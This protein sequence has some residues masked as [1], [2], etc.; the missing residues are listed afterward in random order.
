MHIV[1]GTSFNAAANQ[2]RDRDGKLHL[3][4]VVKGTFDIPMQ[5]T[6]S[7]QV[8]ETQIPI[9]H[10]DVFEGEPGLTA[11]VFESDWV[12]RK[13][14]CDIVVKANA[15]APEGSPIK[16]MTAGFRVG[17]CQKLATVVG[18]RRWKKNRLGVELGNAEPFESMPIKYDN[19]FGGLWHDPDEDKY[20]CYA[21]NPNGRGFAKQFQDQLDETHYGPTIEQP[22]RPVTDSDSD[23]QPWGFGPI[24]RNWSPRSD[25]AG[26]YDDHWKQNVFPLLPADFDERFFQCV[27]EDQ[28]VDFLTGGEE[29][30]LSNLDPEHKSLKFCLP[31]DLSMPVIVV[32]RKRAVVRVTTVADTLSIDATTR[33]FTIVWRGQLPLRRGL[34]EINSVVAGSVCK[35]W[36]KSLIF[37]GS[38]CSC[39]GREEKPSKMMSVDEVPTP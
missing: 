4:L 8:S 23:Y 31:H 34:R 11:P 32:D 12:L 37:G 26:T 36:W 5:E 1:N 13:K 15:Y 21:A 7:P 39:D 38:E 35:R 2:S 20:E 10:S 14:R 27:P 9:F 17:Q 22:D 33:Q 28:Q 16:S 3:L 30:E 19:S 6:Q 18:I 25:Y 24:G 29:V